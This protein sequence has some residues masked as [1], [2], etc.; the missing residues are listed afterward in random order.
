MRSGSNHIRGRGKALT[1]QSALRQQK[2]F[3]LSKRWKKD[4]GEV[5]SST[6]E[7][8]A[9]F[10]TTAFGG[11]VPSAFILAPMPT[12]SSQESV[13]KIFATGKRKIEK[14]KHWP[15]INHWPPFVTLFFCSTCQC[16]IPQ[17]LLTLNLLSVYSPLFQ[18]LLQHKLR[19][20]LSSW[21]LKTLL[22]Y[23]QSIFLNN[24]TG[25]GAEC[26]GG[27]REQSWGEL[28][29]LSLASIHELHVT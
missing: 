5:N 14:F 10:Y 21:E 6:D 24:Q 27:W 28:R 7:P 4:S 1:R 8:R 2:I 19:D 25:V 11:V 13:S 23:T 3:T 17:C 15:L 20:F 16:L 26:A 22:E 18:P 12:G 9:W 29:H